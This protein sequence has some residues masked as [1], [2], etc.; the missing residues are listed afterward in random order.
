[1]ASMNIT[2]VANLA[3]LLTSGLAVQIRDDLDVGETGLGV[4]LGGFFL[5]GALGSAVSGRIV[6]RIGPDT[7][8][9]HAAR[10]TA[11]VLLCIGVF[12]RSWLLLTLFVALGGLA[13]AWAQP[14]AN[15]YI[16]R[17]IS[18]HR[19]GFALGI[20]KSGIPMAALLGGVAVPT[21]GLTIGWNWAFVV[22]GALAFAVSW[23]IPALAPAVAGA[24]NSPRRIQGGEHASAVPRPDVAT[25]LLLILAVVTGL[26]A[27]GSGAFASFF[28]LSTVETGISE[29]SAGLL[30]VGGSI[31]GIGARMVLGA[32]A[33][34]GLRNP[35]HTL[36]AMFVIAAM[37]FAALATTSRTLL[38]IA[39]PFAFATAF[40]WPGLHHFAL[41]RSNPS[42]P[43]AATG[44]TMT[45]SFTG[46]VA[47]PLI[48]GILADH[49][50]YRWAWSFTAVAMVL[51]AVLMV[52]VGPL[53]RLPARAVERQPP[54][55][56]IEDI[57]D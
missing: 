41:V 27:C 25:R 56:D 47:G 29:A 10:V 18:P 15:L 44:I 45:G 52:V 28:V 14:A 39:M 9:R 20:Q 32:R 46:A 1:M 13:N 12:G 33:D 16:A 6:E 26:A 35:W 38:L 3:P 37:S 42:A 54:E 40:A 51:A 2:A 4:S 31:I 7:A 36:S 53:I 11:V 24:Q 5:V 22:G 17:G 23:Y 48:F 8:L 55:V 19:L 21:L 30:L 50:S 57:D 34:R 49:A 43:G